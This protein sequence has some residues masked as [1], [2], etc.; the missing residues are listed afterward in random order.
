MKFLTIIES[1]V[2]DPAWV[3]DY[4]ENVG[5]M[6]AQIGAQYKVRTSEVEVIEGDGVPEVVII[7]EFP[8]RD[9]FYEFYNSR[10]Y[11]PYKNARLAGS[12]TRM[13]LVP[14]MLV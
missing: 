9:A 5:P 3:G 7:A 13:L 11:Q 2:T 10:A 12:N 4:L 6:L 8:S 14:D 1:T